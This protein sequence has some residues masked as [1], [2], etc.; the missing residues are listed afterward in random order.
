ML[1]LAFNYFS[2]FGDVNF[3]RSVVVIVITLYLN[4]PM[5]PQSPIFSL[6]HCNRPLYEEILDFLS[7]FDIVIFALSTY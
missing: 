6:D 1:P 3:V 5:G 2:S 4:C 7:I